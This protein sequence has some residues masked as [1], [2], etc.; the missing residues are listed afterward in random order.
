M[1]INE[2]IFLIKLDIKIE[3]FWDLSSFHDEENEIFSQKFRY[4]F[5]KRFFICKNIIYS[6]FYCFSLEKY[7]VETDKITPII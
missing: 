7:P 4:D 2:I 5:L 3:I 1:G 6:I